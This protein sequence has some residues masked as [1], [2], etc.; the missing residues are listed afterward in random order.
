MWDLIN[1]SKRDSIVLL[2]SFVFFALLFI[3][4]FGAYLIFVFG[5]FLGSVFV[6]FAS[7]YIIIHSIR[8][9]TKGYQ[10]ALDSV[11]AI[12]IEKTEYPVDVKQRLKDTLET[13]AIAAGIPT[14][15]LYVMKSNMI[16]AFATGNDPKNSYVC[17]TTGAV[18]KLNREEIEGVLGHELGHI[19]NGDIRY[20]TFASVLLAFMVTLSSFA[21][22]TLFFGGNR[23]NSG[24][25]I[26]IGL[27]L[28]ALAPLFG[29]L[30]QLAISR[31]REYLADATSARL[32]RNP[33][34][35]ISAL[36]K[37]KEANK[38]TGKVPSKVSALLI[39]EPKSL[40]STHPPIEKRIERLKEMLN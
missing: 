12:P 40:F 33:N 10:I 36:L 3:A 18:E 1:K 28:A 17:L 31:Q 7:L 23:R 27:A 6:F 39:W 34:E 13:L 19:L 4:L 22:R 8:S 9:Y 25:V 20:V 37:I 15:K 21:F 38:Y 5:P 24:I 11:G 32:T 35:L 14:P 26:L 2:V 30:L 29:K 16:N